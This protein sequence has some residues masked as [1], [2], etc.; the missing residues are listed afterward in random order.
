LQLLSTM[1][2][3]RRRRC[4]YLSSLVR[5]VSLLGRQWYTLRNI[6][7]INLITHL[8]LLYRTRFSEHLRD[9]LIQTHEKELGMTLLPQS[10]IKYVPPQKEP[11]WVDA[12]PSSKIA[13]FSMPFFYTMSFS[14]YHHM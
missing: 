1:T 13:L 7:F 12:R 4:L 2:S 3:K 11:L 5:I 10:A 14:L 8:F 6:V 9:T